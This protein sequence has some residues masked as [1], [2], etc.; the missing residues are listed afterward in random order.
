VTSHGARP[1]IVVATEA[2]AA[3]VPPGLRLVITGVGKT[4]AAVGTTRAILEER[5]SEVINV[6]SAGALRDG[7][8]GIFEIGTVLNHDISA[9]AI[10]SIGLDPRDVLE[11]GAS[12]TALA[13]GDVFVSDPVVRERLAQRAHLVDMEG[14][15]VAYAAAS[16]DVP[17][18]LIKH[19]SDNADETALVWVD[20]VAASARAVGEWLEEA[21]NF[22]SEG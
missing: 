16:L 8:A 4:A 17:V 12:P 18:R 20:A 22:S 11:L 2:E 9:D 14:Y 13:T 21:L 1:L 5:P 3:H 10:R 6:G 19:V 15:A 7:L